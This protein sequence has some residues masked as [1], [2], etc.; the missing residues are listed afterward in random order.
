MFFVRELLIK[1]PL[2]RSYFSQRQ[3]ETAPNLGDINFCQIRQPEIRYDNRQQVLMCSWRS[4]FY[5][6]QR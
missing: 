1:I 6:S 2:F 5:K 4:I 3:F